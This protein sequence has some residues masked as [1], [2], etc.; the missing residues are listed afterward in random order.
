MGWLEFGVAML[1]FLA[2]HRIPALFGVK[3]SLVN[4]L[5]PRGY[6]VVFSL[7]STVL[8]FWVIWAAGR[9][10]IVPLW[11][12]AV[13]SRWAVNIVMPVV[14]ALVV[15]GTAASN[16]FA[17]E[18]KA[19]GF[20]PE[21]PGIAGVTRQPLLFALLLWSGV[22]IWANGD[23]AHVILFGVFAVFSVV[24]M[25]LVERRRRRDMGEDAW[26]NLTQHTGLLPFVALVTGRWTPKG[27]PSWKR[28][29]VT[30][31]C[32]AAIWH[33]HMPVIGAYPAP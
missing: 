2:S 32:W 9:A 8:L 22:H 12:Q 33:L 4:A 25:R 15:F 21:K 17:F 19:T 11:D 29:L 30:V 3:Q 10:P 14:L 13:V 6:T 1:I 7:F 28:L 24:G 23:L 20:D 27:A 31:L 5:G 16:P 26:A 18:G